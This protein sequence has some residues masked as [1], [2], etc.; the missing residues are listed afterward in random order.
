MKSVLLSIKPQ[1]LNVVV[2]ES[3]STRVTARFIGESLD[4]ANHERRREA[5]RRIDEGLATRQGFSGGVS[6]A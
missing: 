3:G 1:L 2:L 5:R 6:E 4:L